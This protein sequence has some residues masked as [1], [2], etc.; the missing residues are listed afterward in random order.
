MK[1][2]LPELKEATYSDITLTEM[3]QKRYELTDTYNEVRYRLD[4]TSAQFHEDKINGDKY[5]YAELKKQ[6]R[7]LENHI[8]LLDELITE[9]KLGS[10]HFEKAFYLVAKEELDEGTGGFLPEE[11]N[12]RTGSRCEG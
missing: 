3:L 8:Q 9:R 5:E 6:E 12:R 1:T 10:R 4:Y 7:D 11:A 2:P